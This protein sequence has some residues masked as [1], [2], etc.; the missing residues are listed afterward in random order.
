M[1]RFIT[2]PR[3]AHLLSRI[4]SHTD[5]LLKLQEKEVR[6]HENNWKAEGQHLQ[7]IDKVRSDL[8]TEIDLI[9]SSEEPMDDQN[10][11]QA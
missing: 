10:A 8:Q 3:C 1:Y 6:W 9:I 4:E 11:E 2:S 5:A 7:S